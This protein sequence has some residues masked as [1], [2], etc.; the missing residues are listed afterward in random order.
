MRAHSSASG[1]RA[2][3]VV[4]EPLSVDSYLDYW[5]VSAVVGQ[6]DS[7][8]YGVP[9]DDCHVYPALSLSRSAKRSRRRHHASVSLV[10]ALHA[11]P[12]ASSSRTIRQPMREEV[13]WTRMSWIRPFDDQ[14]ATSETVW[15]SPPKA[16]DV[17]AGDASII[18]PVSAG[19]DAISVADTQQ[20]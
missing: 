19:N 15:T 1:A 14:R 13:V 5:A 10:T 20:G 9:G 2:I 3:G 4:G 18:W 16:R 11:Y 7:Y 17:T 6:F 8:P 12:V